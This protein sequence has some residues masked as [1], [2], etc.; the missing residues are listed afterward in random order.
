MNT[1]HDREDPALG[2]SWRAF[3]QHDADVKA[4]PRIGA[5]VWAAWDDAQR[6][7]SKGHR[8]KRYREERS[9]SRNRRLAVAS[10]LVAAA[11]L[12][13]AIGLSM[14][15]VER[16][17]PSSPAPAARVEAA[18]G[19]SSDVPVPERQ[20]ASPSSANTIVRRPRAI[21]ASPAAPIVTLAVD[22][23]RDTELLQIVRLRLPRRTLE[24]F[25]VALVEPESSG[26]VDVDV[27]VGEDGLPRDIRSIRPVV[28]TG[29]M[30]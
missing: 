4:P 29:G 28:E 11:A 21:P 19:G 16:H 3:A 13:A 27:L 10:A 14:R 2:A 20:A 23:I 25:G 30:E 5:A 7:R 17:T 26:L 22:P 8:S 12:F 9:S 1:S 18:A 15:L 24:T 6:H